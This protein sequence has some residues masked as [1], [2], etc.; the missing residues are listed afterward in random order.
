MPYMLVSMNCYHSLHFIMLLKNAKL[1]FMYIDVG[2]V[3]FM[4]K[5]VAWILIF[6]DGDRHYRL[7]HLKV[8]PIIQKI[9]IC[10]TIVEHFFVFW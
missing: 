8:I 9:N 4:I 1:L 7:N 6:G 5:S 3:V 2:F 10:T